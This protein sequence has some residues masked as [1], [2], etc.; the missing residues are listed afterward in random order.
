MT[1]AV[2]LIDHRKKKTLD[3]VQ[4]VHLIGGGAPLAA[5]ISWPDSRGAGARR[6]PWTLY[7]DQA[8]V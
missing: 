1:D 4:K 8:T 5:P 3:N 2:L 7:A 6:P